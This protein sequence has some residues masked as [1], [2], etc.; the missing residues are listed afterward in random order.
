MDGVVAYFRGVSPARLESELQMLQR[1]SGAESFVFFMYGEEAWRQEL[2]VAELDELVRRLGEPPSAA[3]TIC[4]RHGSAAIAS[5]AALLRLLQTFPACVVDDDCGALW[6]SN[7]LQAFAATV[8][9]EGLFGL[10]GW[11]GPAD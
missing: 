4:S 3:A 8:P 10:R 1:S 5:L 9:A 2:E 6:N 7:D 11:A